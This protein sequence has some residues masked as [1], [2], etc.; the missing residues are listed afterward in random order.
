MEFHVSMPALHLTTLFR[1]RG[2]PLYRGRDPW[3]LTD[4]HR[5][6]EDTRCLRTSQA[7]LAHLSEASP[8]TNIDALVGLPARGLGGS[9]AEADDSSCLLEHTGT[10]PRAEQTG[11]QDGQRDCEKA[12]CCA[13]AE[14]PMENAPG[15][16]SALALWE[17]VRVPESLL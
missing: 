17:R 3:S 5:D 10:R 6:R 14:R 4:D 15:V 9:G 12:V 11:W 7:L 1:N 16:T 8:F 13:R 2:R